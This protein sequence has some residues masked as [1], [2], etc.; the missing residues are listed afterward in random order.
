MLKKFR[1]H[2]SAALSKIP[3]NFPS[4][5]EIFSISTV[6]NKCI[7]L[8]I[9]FKSPRKDLSTKRRKKLF[10]NIQQYIDVIPLFAH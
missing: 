9:E 5:S 1:F 3:D 10:S 6:D 8:A 2:I 4:Y 7:Y